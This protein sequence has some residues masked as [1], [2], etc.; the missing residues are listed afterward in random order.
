MGAAVTATPAV[1]I[2]LALRVVAVRTVLWRGLLLLGLSAGDEGGQAADIAAAAL[3]LLLLW[4]RRIMRLL[5]LHD[6]LRRTHVLLRHRLRP[7]VGLRLL[8][9]SA[10]RLLLL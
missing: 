1:L 9:L 10:I 3:R 6:R 5:L 2:A 4:L 8:L 7:A